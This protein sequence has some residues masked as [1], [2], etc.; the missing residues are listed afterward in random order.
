[1]SQNL[2]KILTRGV[3]AI[4]PSKESFEKAAR[5]RQL[6]IYNGIDPTAA[7]LHLGHLVILRKLAQFQNLEHKIIL[8]IGDFTAT[9]GDPSGKLEARKQ[10]TKGQVLENAKDYKNQAGKILSFGGSNAAEIRFN[11]AWLSKLNLGQILQLASNFTTPQLL[12]RDMFQKRLAAGNPIFLHELMYPL[13]QGYDSVA[14]KVDAEIGGSDQIFNMLVGRDLV[15]RYLGKEKFVLATKLLVVGEVKMGKTES[16]FVPL[17]LPN[18]E[19]FGKIMAIPDSAMP[20]FFELLTDVG[21]EDWGRLKP[22]EAKKLLAKEIL[23]QLFKKDE[24]LKAQKEFERVFQEKE[25]P[26]QAQI[27]RPK[28]KSYGIL[29]LLTDAKLVNS[30]SEAKRMVNQGA[31]EVNQKVVR[32][33]KAEIEAKIGTIIKVG[34]YKFIQIG[35]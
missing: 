34:K 9:I 32:D 11:S 15:K 5:A 21:T 7:S 25:L 33:I 16:V 23:L 28:G 35:K 4:Y 18:N 12:E 6:T 14:M 19:M 24:V 29:D 3:E 30:K 1:M 20:S 26:K 13:L 17:T 8:L 31:V 10:L 22:L 2:E 27:F